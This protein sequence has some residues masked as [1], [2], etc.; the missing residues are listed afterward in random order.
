MQ[1]HRPGGE[2]ESSKFYADLVGQSS[3]PPLPPTEQKNFCDICG[4]SIAEES[5][6]AHYRSVLHNFNRQLPPLVSWGI[7]PDNKGY[8]MLMRIGW[9][10][11]KGLGLEEQG[12]LFPVET[13]FKQDRTGLGKQAAPKRITHFP[14]HRGGDQPLS[15]QAQAA[16]DLRARHVLRAKKLSGTLHAASIPSSM[17]RKDLRRERKQKEKNIQLLQKKIDSLIRVSLADLPSS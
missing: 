6:D 7:G 16:V 14:S 1:Y 9:Q 10:E 2:N 17:R 5:F 8:Q 15:L 13:S 12:R 3:P 11:E 4:E